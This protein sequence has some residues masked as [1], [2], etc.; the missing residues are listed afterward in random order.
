MIACVLLM[1]QG[2]SEIIKRAA[3]MMGIIPDSNATVISAQRAAELEAE[4]LVMNI[5]GE[6]K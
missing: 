5:A 6:Q 2:I 3:M 4:R 1:V